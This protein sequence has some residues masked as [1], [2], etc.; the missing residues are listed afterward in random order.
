MYVKPQKRERPKKPLCHE[1]YGTNERRVQHFNEDKS[2]DAYPMYNEEYGA[3]LMRHGPN[4][5]ILWQ[6]TKPQI[7]QTMYSAAVR[8]S[9][10]ET[11]Q[12]RFS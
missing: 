4:I 5:S 3:D 8:A 7:A 9:R 12:R 6:I 1:S 11:I 2:L 10:K